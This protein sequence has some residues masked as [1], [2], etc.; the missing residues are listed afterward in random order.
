MPGAGQVALLAAAP[1]MHEQ[2][3][4][5]LAAGADQGADNAVIFDLQ[6]HG[7]TLNGHVRGS[8]QIC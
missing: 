4:R 5:H 3:A 6:F 8:A 2:N 1:A 7:L